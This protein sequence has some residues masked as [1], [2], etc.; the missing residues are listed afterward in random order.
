MF[1]GGRGKRAS[2]SHNH[3]GVTQNNFAAMSKICRDGTVCAV[4]LRR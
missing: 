4:T 2:Q 3:S 1:N